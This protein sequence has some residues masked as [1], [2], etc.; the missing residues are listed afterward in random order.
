LTEFYGNIPT[1]ERD[2]APDYQSACERVVYFLFILL[3]VI[4]NVLGESGQ[5]L[6]EFV[7]LRFSR[8]RQAR[9]LEHL[10]VI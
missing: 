7:D 5:R 3:H 6:R 4:E 10:V 1:D 2:I 8:L 9:V